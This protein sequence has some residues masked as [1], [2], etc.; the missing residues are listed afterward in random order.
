ME[1]E[2]KKKA[3]T[4]SLEFMIISLLFLAAVFVFGLI[5]HEAVYENEKVFDDK[6]FTFFDG[7]STPGLISFMEVVTFFG[8]TLFLIPAYAVLLTYFLIKR[9]FAYAIQVAIIAVSSTVLM[10]L[11]KQVF[12]RQRPEFPIIEGITS[13]SFPSGH[14][15]SSFIFFSVLIY[16]SFNATLK[17]A[18]RWVSAI[19]FF[20]F[21]VAI[22]LS[23]I[24]LRVH[25]PTDVIASFCLGTV[26]VT[27][28][29]WILKKINKAKDSNA[30]LQ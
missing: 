18:L 25:Y 20:L 9:R 26:W 8:S 10:F 19:F 27:L 16:I 13:Y 3:K 14:A 2:S 30:N 24:I 4:I 15:L 11:L 21:A 29:F 28:S 23:R 12:H 17:L 22:A 1:N 6:V 7:I 5:A